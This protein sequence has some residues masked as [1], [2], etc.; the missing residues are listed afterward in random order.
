M[1][2]NAV[3]VRNLTFSYRDNTKSVLKNVSFDLEKGG[4]LLVI[5]E[6]G[7]GKT[8]LLQHLKPSY[9]PE[10]SREEGWD[11]CINGKRFY[12]MSEEELAFTVGYVGQHVE[13]V[14]V[15]DK[16]WHELAFGL[17]SL[18][19]NQDYI[20]RRVA[21]TAA[22]FGLEN[23][24]HEKLSKLS[25]GQKQ[26]VNLA[27]VMVMEP[28]ILIL[29]EPTSQLDP[30]SAEEFFHMIRKV[31]EELGTTMVMAEH[32]LWHWMMEG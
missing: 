2:S 21:E 12:E 8:T 22:F 26:L 11:I 19:K 31:H 10:G 5:G 3:E 32:R 20:R 1:L 4:I 14:Q 24:F 7:C 23:V 13:A 28:E 6:S 9:M 30:I 29:D 16:V 27:S 18:G 15:T 17:E 25:G